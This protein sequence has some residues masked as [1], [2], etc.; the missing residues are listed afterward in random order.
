MLC[1][2]VLKITAI[3][4]SPRDCGGN[5]TDILI[6]SGQ[7][8][9][10]GQTESDPTDKPVA[11]ASEYRL[12]TDSFVPLKN[13]VGEDFGELLLAS[14]LGHGSLVPYFAESYCKVGG[15][16]VVCVHAAK[17]ATIISQWLP[18]REEGKER[19]AALLKKAKACFEKTTDEI[20]NVF[21]VW[22]QGESDALAGTTEDDYL[23]MLRELIADLKKDLGITAFMIIKVGYFA[24]MFGRKE[25]DEAIMR[26]Q[27]RAAE[28]GTAIMLTD[29]ATELSREGKNLNP[30]AAGHFNNASMKIIGRIAGENAAKKASGIK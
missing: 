23:A 18:S 5:M 19:Y 2:N 4:K 1:Y 13:P 11:G 22:L 16:K 6:F 21:F 30:D 8:N 20:G 12:L 15:R 3:L 29:V 28:E 24:S 9:M 17:G 25:A 10:Q 26:A 14:H 27:E 7:S